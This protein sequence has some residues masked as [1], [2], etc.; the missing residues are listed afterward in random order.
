MI[1]AGITCVTTANTSNSTIDDSARTHATH[2]V[3][4]DEKLFYEHRR[5][6]VVEDV[7]SNSK[8][9]VRLMERAGHVTETA[10]NGQEAIETIKAD[11]AIGDD[12]DHQPFDTVLM[13]YEMRK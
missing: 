12:I 6:L 5:V 10:M 11:M 7:I 2:L 13:D 8:M 1:G 9:L 3:V 4:G